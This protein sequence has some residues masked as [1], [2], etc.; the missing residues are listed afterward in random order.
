M[1]IK[2]DPP[3]YGANTYQTNNNLSH[4]TSQV[5]ADS[6][7]ATESDEMEINELLNI[8]GDSQTNGAEQSSGFTSMSSSDSMRSTAVTVSLL[9]RINP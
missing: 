5:G 6:T 3:S 9:S 2:D 4:L 7:N 8:I 1:P